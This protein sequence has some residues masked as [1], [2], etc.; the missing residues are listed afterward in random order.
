MDGIYTW[1]LQKIGLKEGGGKIS[2]RENPAPGIGVIC[3]FTFEK[4]LMHLA[5]KA[6]Y[7]KGVT[8]S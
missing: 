4:Q 3:N 2:V 7:K 8:E 5:S 1:Y 6:A